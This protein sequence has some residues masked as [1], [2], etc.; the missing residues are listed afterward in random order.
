M[1][2]INFLGDWG[3]Q[4]GLLAFGL[5]GQNIKEFQDCKNYHYHLFILV[6]PF[7]SYSTEDYEIPQIRI[8]LFSEE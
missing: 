8:Q 1:T 7:Y 5:Q 4:F 2:R 3:T 6:D